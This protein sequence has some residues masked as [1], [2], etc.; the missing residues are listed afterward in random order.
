VVDER[1]PKTQ[2]IR[3]IRYVV[4]AVV[5]W[6]AVVAGLLVT[7]I[8]ELDQ[9]MRDL[10]VTEARTHFDQDQEVRFWITTHGG[11]YV[12]T[13]DRTPPNPYLRH[14]SDRDIVTPSGTRLTLMNPAYAMRQMHEEFVGARGI[15]G[16][17]T[18]LEPLRPENVPD[19][20]E[21][22]A[23]AR[24]KQGE[25][26]ALEFALAGGAPYL[27]LMRPVVTEEGCLKCHGVQGYEV[28]DI[29]GGVSV[30]VPMTPYLAD[31][32]RA[33]A[34]HCLS[35]GALWILGIG[36]LG[37]GTRSLRR[38]IEERGRAQAAR[39]HLVAA[40]EQAA[41]AVIVTDA[42]GTI[43]YVSPAF[44][45]ITGRPPEETVGDIR[46]VLGSEQVSSERLVELESVL[47]RGET[48]R[49]RLS[50]RRPDG[51][52]YETE[53]TV[54]PVRDASGETVNFV[55]VMRDV[56]EET[57]LRAQ[58]FQA[59]KME[60]VGHLAAGIAHDFNNVL[61]AILGY[62]ELAERGLAQDDKLYH[63]LEQIHKGAERAA[64][65]T[66]Q[67]LAFS[68]Q[69]IMEPKDTDLNEL[70]A[71]LLKM[72]RRVISEDIALDFVPGHS[73]GTVHVDATQIEQ[74]LMNLCVNARDAM[75]HGGTLTME[76]ENVFIDGSYRAVHPWAREGR[77]VLISIT[78]TGEGM[79]EAT[80]ERLFEPFF[81][82]KEVGK[83]TGLGLATAYGIVKQH[84]GLIHVYSEPD[85][86]TVFKIYLPTVEREA[87]KAES[88]VEAPIQGGTETILVA[89]DDELVRGVI[90]RVLEDA[91][92]TLLVAGNGQEAVELFAA[93]AESISLALLDVIMPKLSGKEA[94][95][96]MRETRPDLRVVF[97][98]GYSVNVVHA[99]FVLNEGVALLRKPF[100][101]EGLLRKVREAL[102]TGP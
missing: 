101:S 55:G 98:S 9:T 28:G 90:V 21:A 73:I 1:T 42:P 43:E 15:V 83:G 59:Q 44:E 47:A 2:Q 70:I 77:Y 20:W 11:V 95:A 16:H 79:D 27:R 84:D 25:E 69:Q 50:G 51:S 19:D 8:R 6:T 94:A 97:T 72:I 49:G 65:L 75:P 10:A 87:E 68:R 81:T 85:K 17:I 46:Q 89:E 45:R 80:L 92:Y 14:L 35:M 60:A 91:G 3:L 78:D 48:W 26:E 22:A 23:L 56:T 29:R 63:D 39:K 38:R 13:N 36:G 52:V 53:T 64:A 41:E 82:T 93:H 32:R 86:G 40:I 12:P 33:V 5:V 57:S 88:V 71:D 62:A 31:K 96:R 100:G 76:T 74:V 58:L 102:D 66:R 18:S 37:V 7:Q 30:S 67:L 61:G 99:E 34:S 54:S 24:F 4:V